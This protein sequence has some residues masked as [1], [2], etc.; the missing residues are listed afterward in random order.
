VLVAAPNFIL[1][2]LLL[3]QRAKGHHCVHTMDASFTV[4]R[5]FA[6]KQLKPRLVTFAA[7]SES[8]WT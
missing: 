4:S 6:S 2:Q 7:G 1:Q 5:V 3:E 8:N